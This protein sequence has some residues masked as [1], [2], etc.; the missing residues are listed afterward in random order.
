MGKVVA[1][2]GMSHAPGA[3]GFPETANPS[4]RTKLET[5]SKQLGSSLKSSQPDVIFAFLDDHFANFFRELMPSIAISVADSHDEPADQWMEALRIDKRT[6][7]PGAPDIAEKMLAALVGKGWGLWIPGRRTTCPVVPIFINVFTPPLIPY[8]RAYAFG[9]AVRDAVETALPGETKVA[10][11]ATGGLSHWPPYWNEFQASPDDAFLNR[12]RRY[13]TEGKGVLEEDPN[14]FV[15]FEEY[16]TEMARKNEWP[17]DKGHHPLVNHAWDRLFMEKFVAGDKE[18]M[19]NLTY[20]EV[21][22]EAGHG[23]HEVLKWLALLG[24]MRG[25][26]SMLLAYE[27]VLEWICGMTS[28]DFEVSKSKADTNGGVKTNGVHA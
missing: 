12:M 24:A 25:A 3:I 19:T 27:P 21:E 7:F 13:Q 14:L 2:V 18:W 1:A 10:F 4:I 5:A 22:R 20:E 11:L 23:A 6:V 8:W 26:P 16:E 9:K 28:V 15:D 17:V